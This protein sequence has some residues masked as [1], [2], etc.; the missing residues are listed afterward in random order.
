MSPDDLTAKR[1]HR[2]RCKRYHLRRIQSGGSVLADATDA[3][4]VLTDLASR[5]SLTSI[6]KAL[7]TS[8]SYV[9]KIIRGDVQRIAHDKRERI[10]ELADYLP[11]DTSHVTATGAMRRVRALHAIGYSWRI[12][13]R[14]I[15]TYSLGGIKQLAYGFNPV[16]EAHHDKAVREAFKRLSMTLPT[17]DNPHVQS[18][19]TAARNSA[20]RKGWLPP[21]AWDDIDRDPEPP[22]ALYSG[23]GI[24]PVV[25]LR[26]LEGD[27][28]V[29]SNAAEKDEAMR[30]WR[31]DG[32]SERELCIALGWKTG[33]YGRLRVVEE[34]S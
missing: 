8:H 15:P 25:V 5:M 32:G 22:T 23:P 34:A 14:E 2:R 16:V 11:E 1:E 6:G 18:G 30:Q 20:R 4:E 28:T 29:T 7:G 19:I 17:S 24:D 31:A 12:L 33:R 9:S 3:R 13:D 27:R 26:L 10:L 21:L